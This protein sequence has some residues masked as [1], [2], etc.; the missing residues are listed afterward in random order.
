MDEKRL[1]RMI[2]LA[3]YEQEDGKEDIAISRYYRAD[4]IGLGLLKNIILITIAYI[5]ILGLIII[6]NFESLAVEF[7]TL[8]I[9][10]LMW[11]ILIIYLLII[12]IFSVIVFVIRRMRYEKAA[13]R[14]HRYYKKLHELGEFYELE[15]LI[16]EEKGK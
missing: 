11:G 15:D 5:I 2:H 14:I 16:R 12:G 3:M 10:P 8:N 4:Y 1:S 9:Q 7:S 6:Y 13:R